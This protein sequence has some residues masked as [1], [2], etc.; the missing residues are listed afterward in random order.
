[1]FG[2]TRLETE[3]VLKW[4]SVGVCSLTPVVWALV[5]TKLRRETHRILTYDNDDKVPPV[6]GQYLGTVHFIDARPALHV[7][8]TRSVETAA[9]ELAKPQP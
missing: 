9:A 1:M 5:D 7:F 6:E 3:H 2:E 4:L 8:Q